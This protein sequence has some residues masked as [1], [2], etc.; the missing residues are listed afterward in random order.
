MDS[1]I[2]MRSDLLLIVEVDGNDLNITENSMD[3]SDMVITI[4]YLIGR[5]HTMSNIP[6]TEIL[7]DL[8]KAYEEPIT[9]AETVK[10]DKESK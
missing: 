1:T 2:D 5:L 4:Q 6:S 10:E 7:D 9:E 3:P 8:K